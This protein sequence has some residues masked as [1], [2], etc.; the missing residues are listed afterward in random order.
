MQII[1]LPGSGNLKKDVLQQRSFVKKLPNAALSHVLGDIHYIAPWIRGKQVHTFHDLESLLQGNQVSKTLKKYFWLK[2]AINYSDSVSV[3][4]A[5]TQHKLIREIPQAKSKTR[6][7]HNPL[8]LKAKGQIEKDHGIF[9]VISIGAK[10]NKNLDRIAQALSQIQIPFHWHIVGDP[11]SEQYSFFKTLNLPFSTYQDLDIDQLSRLYSKCH[12]LLFPSLYEGFGLPILEAQAHG[13]AV[14]TANT[15]AMPEVAG[16][17]AYLVNP[18]D[19]QD[20]LNGIEVLMNSEQ[21]RN[22]ITEAGYQNIK[23]YQIESVASGYVHWYED[24][25]NGKE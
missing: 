11:A 14:L 12:I 2:Q 1:E 13:V 18:I 9:H 22:K 24:V 25:L 5:H 20:I 8:L 3:I 23:E 6:V 21:L 19:T 17:G 15:T 4:S 16:E 10:K 7:I